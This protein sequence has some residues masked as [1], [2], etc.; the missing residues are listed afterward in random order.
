MDGDDV[1]KSSDEPTPTM[2]VSGIHVLGQEQSDGEEEPEQRQR[3]AFPINATELWQVGGMLSDAIN[4]L[5]DENDAL[6][7]ELAEVRAQLVAQDEKH[8]RRVTQL[9]RL[10]LELA[11]RVKGSLD[12][13][14]YQRSQL[15]LRLE[16]Y[17]N[18][19]DGIEKLQR[20]QLDRMLSVWRKLGWL[21]ADFDPAAIDTL[22]GMS[23]QHL[24]DD[25]DTRQ[26]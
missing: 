6:R 25:K 10:V 19:P 18:P 14:A 3:F 22:M 17:I 16:N 13:E 21:S 15:S 7:D 4:G 23:H 11:E 1:Y 24:T 26:N 8:D 5:M 9:R 12:S 2:T 20:M